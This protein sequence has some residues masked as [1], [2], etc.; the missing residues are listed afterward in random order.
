MTP[1]ELR[2]LLPPLPPEP[3]RFAIALNPVGDRMDYTAKDMQDFALAF[4][5]IVIQ[6]QR[7]IDAGI[8]SE[9]HFGEDSAHAIRSQS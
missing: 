1:D 4:G 8:A 2:A 6:R 3:L 5:R 9:W 7:E